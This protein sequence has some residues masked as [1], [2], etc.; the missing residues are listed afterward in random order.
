MLRFLSSAV[1]P[2]QK[3]QKCQLP[4]ITQSISLT[5]RGITSERIVAVVGTITPST[6]AGAGMC[7][8]TGPTTSV[9][10]LAY[11]E[12]SMLSTRNGIEA[13][14]VNYIFAPSRD[15]LHAHC[16]GGWYNNSL[17]CR[18]TDRSR[19]EPGDYGVDL[20]FRLGVYQAHHAVQFGVE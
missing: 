16:G 19:L 17:K 20:G 2:G 15:N 14:T 8:A 18:T 10:D 3:Q 4:I 11:T 5:R 13:M 12:P 9:F 7:R 1:T 6:A